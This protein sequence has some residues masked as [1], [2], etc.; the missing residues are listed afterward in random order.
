MGRSYTVDELVGLYCEFIRSTPGQRPTARDFASHVALSPAAL[1]RYVESMSEIER[2]ADRELWRRVGIDAADTIDFVGLLERWAATNPGWLVHLSDFN[3]PHELPEHG[4][5]ALVSGLR[6][7]RRDVALE[8][9]LG[10]ICSSWQALRDESRFRDTLVSTAAALQWTI[11]ALEAARSESAEF[12][13]QGVVSADELYRI[14]LDGDMGLDP[15][16]TALV[17]FIDLHHRFPSV[18]EMTDLFGTTIGAIYARSNKRELYSRLQVG[19]FRASARLVERHVDPTDRISEMRWAWMMFTSV[20]V[21]APYLA[22]M[23]IDWDDPAENPSAWTLD[24]LTRKYGN[25]IDE[26]SLSTTDT[27]RMLMGFVMRQGHRAAAGEDVVLET[28]AMVALAIQLLS[29]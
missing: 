13:P 26:R 27:S 28:F 12:P 4:P 29:H 14:I 19:L 3:R 11:E 17:G 5:D 7:A 24:R 8:L 21:T 6:G 16:V 25:P 22:S 23:Q 20:T 18:R 9:V 2:R 15:E 1:Y 10:F